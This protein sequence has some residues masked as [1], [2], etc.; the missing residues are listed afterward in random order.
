MPGA[1][2]LGDHAQDLAVLGDQI[3]GRRR[4]PPG[5]RSRAIAEFGVAHAGIMEH[6]HRDRLVALVEIGRGA[7]MM[8][9]MPP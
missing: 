3:M 8:P 1:I 2:L 7:S 6:D 4:A 5:S 9:S